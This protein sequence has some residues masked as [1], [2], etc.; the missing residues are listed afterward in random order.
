M[1]VRPRPAVACVTLHMQMLQT[2]TDDGTRQRP[3]QVRSG[4]PT[5]YVDGPVINTKN[6]AHTIR[7]DT[8]G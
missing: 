4:P 3:L 8:A 2:T 1:D 7:T 5:L 6:E